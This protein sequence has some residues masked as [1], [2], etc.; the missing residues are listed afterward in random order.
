MTRV[1]D[2]IVRKR[3]QLLLNRLEQRS[4]VTTGKVRAANGSREHRIAH[5]RE[6]IADQ[7]DVPGRVAG[8]VPHKELRCAD[9]EDLAIL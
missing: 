4:V 8:R 9:L 6:S 2:G 3:E 7:A 1:Q 5:Q